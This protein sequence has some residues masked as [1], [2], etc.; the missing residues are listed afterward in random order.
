MGWETL[1]AFEWVDYVVNGE[2]EAA[3]VRLAR[4]LADGKTVVDVPGVSFR[5]GGRLCI[6]RRRAPLADLSRVPRPDYADY[7]S[8]LRRTGLAGRLK[9]TLVFEGARGCWWGEKSHCLFC[10]HNGLAMKFRRKTPT[11]VLRELMHFMR[12]YGV[13][14]FQASENT[15]DM[16]F[17][18]KFFPR[19]AE[20]L[21]RRRL[22]PTFFYEIRATLSKEQLA[23]LA[24]A[25]ARYLQP[26]IESFDTDLLRKMR[27]GVTAIRN[28]QLLKHCRELDILPIYMMLYG[29]PMEKAGNYRT[30]MRLLPRLTHLTPPRALNRVR[31][32][33]FS[34]LQ[35][36]PRRWGFAA[37]RPNKMY[38]WVY[39]K[40]R[41]DIGKI[42]YYFQGK[43]RRRPPVLDTYFEDIEKF[44]EKW[45]ALYRRSFL[46]HRSVWNAVI[47]YD[48]RLGNFESG[49]LEFRVHR[50]EGRW[51]A[52]VLEFCDSARRWEELREHLLK[53]GR[54]ENEGELR[55]LLSRMVRDGIL[56]KEGG[57]YL[58]LS[59]PYQTQGIE[60]KDT[61]LRLE[62][63]RDLFE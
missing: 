63:L 20:E 13:E 22:E 43:P 19:L 40:S 35:E 44:V 1:R 46:V 5:E 4:A 48:H 9:P 6:D 37:V 56:L 18:R 42:A 12:E 36:D 15:V 39:P 25:G 33:R 53:A 3:L 50:Y 57:C 29:F 11:R 17:P 55:R 59:L 24:A 47:V 23:A 41:V 51:P 34:P 38:D 49:G 54:R 62:K 32:D 28:I 27:K 14:Q 30:V 26:G 60:L 10:G 21:K 58:S 45:K 61:I 7:F 52:R 31:L 2:G 16:E 8:A